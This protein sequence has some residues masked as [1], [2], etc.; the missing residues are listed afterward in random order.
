MPWPPPVTM[1]TR[2]VNLMAHFSFRCSPRTAGPQPRDVLQLAQPFARPGRRG[3]QP[4]A[5]AAAVEALDVVV[6]DAGLGLVG[7]IR[8]LEQLFELALGARN[9]GLVREVGGEEQGA[10]TDALDGRG[11][12]G[13]T[14]LA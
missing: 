11:E 12:R 8:T 10:V 7:Q 2:P 4:R 9:V 6:D 14:A 13:L 3:P 1:A 5:L